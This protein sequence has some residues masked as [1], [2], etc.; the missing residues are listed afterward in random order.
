MTLR[1]VKRDD[2]TTVRYAELVGLRAA[3]LELSLLR[4]AIGRMPEAARIWKK[5]DEI[6]EELDNDLPF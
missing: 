5:L 1:S 4:V 2:Y 3:D 6:K